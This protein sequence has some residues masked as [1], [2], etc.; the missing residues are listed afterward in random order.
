MKTRNE[1]QSKG[2][3]NFL[4]FHILS[5]S[6]FKISFLSTQ[7]RHGIKHNLYLSFIYSSTHHDILKRS[8]RKKEGKKDSKKVYLKATQN[9]E[10]RKREKEKNPFGHK[11][12]R[13]NERTCAGK[14]S[15]IEKRVSEP[16]PTAQKDAVRVGLKLAP[17]ITLPMMV[18]RKT[19]TKTRVVV[20]RKEG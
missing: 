11:K 2:P 9:R 18:K 7:T 3:Q 6:N 8:K 17:P 15:A 10:N 12:G 16:R 14:R 20:T 5:N 19:R 1:H 4:S 13:S